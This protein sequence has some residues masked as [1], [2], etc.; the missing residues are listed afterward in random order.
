MNI[1]KKKIS[2]I[3]LLSIMITLLYLVVIPSAYKQTTSQTTG[4]N[5]SNNLNNKT[6]MKH[7]GRTAFLMAVF[8]ENEFLTEVVT[9]YII[10][11]NVQDYTKL[12][13]IVFSV[14]IVMLTSF[15]ALIHYRKNFN[16]KMNRPKSVIALSKGGHAPP[17]ICHSLN[18]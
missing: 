8:N 13:K 3:L 2:Y 18:N 6:P 12:L 7:T 5:I 14:F 1:S 10:N 16:G 15:G 11:S 4:I 17:Q 9:G